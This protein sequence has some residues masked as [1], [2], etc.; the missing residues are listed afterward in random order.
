M[1][2]HQTCFYLKKTLKLENV[3][4]KHYAPNLMPDPKGEWSLKENISELHYGICLSVH[5][6]LGL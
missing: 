1:Q 4:V 3:F 5:L 6:H 2:D